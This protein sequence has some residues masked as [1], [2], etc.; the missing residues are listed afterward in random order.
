MCEDYMKLFN[1]T[2]GPFCILSQL[3]IVIDSNRSFDLL[4]GYEHD[5]L[6]G[7]NL[8]RLLHPDDVQLFN[9]TSTMSD[10]PSDDS[11]RKRVA[12]I[13]SK[14]NSYINITWRIQYIGVVFFCTV[15]NAEPPVTIGS[16]NSFLNK[17]SSELRLP[18]N[19]LHAFTT[20]LMLDDSIAGNIRHYLE[21][22]SHSC[23]NLEQMLES[24]S[25]ATGDIQLKPVNI[26]DNIMCATCVFVPS[27]TQ[28]SKSIDFDPSDADCYINA[29]PVMFQQIIQNLVGNA[30]KYN[31]LGGKVKIYCKMDSPDPPDKTKN[32]HITIEDNGIGMTQDQ[33][34]NLYQPFNRLGREKEAYPGV[35]I[36]LCLV[37]SHVNL[38]GGQISCSSIANKGTCF[39]VS[40]PII[41]YP[42]S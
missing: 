42:V 33:L 25:Q 12:R 1:A 26:Y 27:L 15:E 2:N 28:S 23:S 3:M 8:I 40:F 37:K 17:I 9:L 5:D 22:I 4:L 16:D 29:E 11:Q 35:G 19:T 7:K 20:L 13:S 39:I 38:F 6:V 31:T 36:G 10:S 18:L 14:E 21:L 24:L 41:N 34:N 30:L 32:I